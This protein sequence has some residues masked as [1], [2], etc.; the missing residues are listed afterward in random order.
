MPPSDF[1]KVRSH[2]GM[3]E[4]G[5]TPEGFVQQQQKTEIT[6]LIAPLNSRSAAAQRLRP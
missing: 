4:R 1:A 6:G 3:Q 2:A 5:E